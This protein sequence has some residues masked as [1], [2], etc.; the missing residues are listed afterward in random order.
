MTLNLIGDALAAAAASPPADAREAPARPAA[1]AAETASMLRH[2]FGVDFTIIDGSSGNVLRVA[3]DQPCQDWSYR[4]EVCQEVARRGQPEFIEEDHPLLMLAVPVPRGE[5]GLVGVATFLTRSL[6]TEAEIARAAGFLRC[7]AQAARHWSYRQS[8]TS[9]DMLERLST[10]V[11]GRLESERRIETLESEVDKLSLHVASTYEEIS[12]IYRLTQ[13]LRI[14][15]QEA[16]LGRMAL[17]WLVEIMPCEGMALLLLPCQSAPHRETKADGEPRLIT[18]GHCPVS[19]AE[20]LELVEELGLTVDAHP[21]VVNRTAASSGRWSAPHVRQLILVPIGEGRQLFGY[22]AA[23]NHTSGK[24][25]GT[26]EADLLSSIAAILGI[27]SGNAELYRQQAELLSGIVQALTS[28]IDAKD[29][30]T[31][32]HSDR[33]ARVAVRVAQEMGCSQSTIETIHLAGL[34]HDVGKIGIDDGVLRKPGKLTPAEFEHIQQHV[35]IGHNILVDLKQL[36]KVLPVVLHHHESWDGSGYPEGLAGEQI[37]PLA[38]IVAV[39]DAFDAM[40]SDRPYRQGMDDEKLDNIIR[41]GAG[42]QWDPHVVA[43]FF[44]AREDIREIA[45]RESSDPALELPHF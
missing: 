24:E 37:P 7:D 12:L 5:T 11:L 39:A 20:F 14:N 1:D 19:Q 22:L 8:V 4:A 21:L 10:L 28:A 3:T 32:G 2:W 30:Y 16:E 44:R 34:L 41:N 42:K 25:F 27:H 35:R 38:R 33:V 36:D 9:G 23:F 31:C 29:P 13:N 17:E 43:A 45:E 40:K 18:N 15:A 26:C 6:E